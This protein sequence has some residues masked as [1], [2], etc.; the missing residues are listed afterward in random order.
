MDILQAIDWF[1][2][3]GAVFGDDH[4]VIGGQTYR[5]DSGTDRSLVRDMYEIADNL[6]RAKRYWAKLG[7]VP[8]NEDGEIEEPFMHFI[9]GTDREE[10][11]GWFEE[12]FKVSVA[13]DLMYKLTV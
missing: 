5:L 11:W 2:K 3:V 12:T 13:K 9:E 6:E 10:I 8:V 7:E 1:Y 4:V